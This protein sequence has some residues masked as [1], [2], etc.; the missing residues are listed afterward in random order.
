MADGCQEVRRSSNLDGKKIRRYEGKL[1]TLKSLSSNLPTLLSSNNHS[2][3]NTSLILPYAL[4]KC[5]AFTLAEVLITLGIIGVVAALT[6]PTLISN[7]RKQVY[8]TQLKKSVSTVENALKL[9]LA[10]EGVDD[11]ASTKFRDYVMN[12]DSN[13]LRKYFNLSKDVTYLSANEREYRTLLIDKSS[14]EHGVMDMKVTGY[15]TPKKLGNC[16]L[17]SMADGSEICI[18]SLSTTSYSTFANVYIDVNGYDKYPNTF[19]YDMFFMMYNYNG[20][21]MLSSHEN[22]CG[23]AGFID[24]ACFDRVVM[25]GWQILY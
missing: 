17:L 4:K 2:G 18:S 23:D 10:D 1:F 7:H 13:A 6:L 9:V 12:R 16:T 5:A 20:S 22:Y 15:G 11:L 24:P 8:I 21:V 19:G 25:D 3:G 14:S